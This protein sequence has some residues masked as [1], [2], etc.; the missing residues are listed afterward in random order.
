MT[1]PASALGL[2][3]LLLSALLLAL[4]ASVGSTGFE[5]VLRAAQ[6]PV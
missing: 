1:R 4:G 6:D 3:L 5:S 2:G